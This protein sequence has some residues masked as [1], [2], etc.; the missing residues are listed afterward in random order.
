MASIAIIGAGLMGRLVALKLVQTQR[1]NTKHAKTVLKVCLFDKDAKTGCLSAA[2]AA[3]GLLTPLGESWCCENWIVEMGFDALALWPSILTQLELPVFFQRQG[4]V[5]VAHAED[6]GDMHRFKRHLKVNWPQYDGH[7]LDSAALQQLEPQLKR[8]NGGLY[9]PSEG[10]IDNRQLLVALRH[11]LTLAEAQG[12]FEWHCQQSVSAVKARSVEV[13]GE[14]RPFDLVIDC[15]G[16]GAA[17]QIAD[18]RGVRGELFRLYAPEVKLTRPV[19]LMHPRY[20][21]YIAP[22]PDH[23]YVIG[24]TEIESNDNGPMTVRSALEL[25][26]AAYSVH[27]GF[28]EASIVEHISQCRPAFDNNHPQIRVADGLIQVNGLYRHGFLL[29]PVVLEHLIKVIERLGEAFSLQADGNKDN[30]LAQLSEGL[31]YP[32]LIQRVI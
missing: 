14:L 13:N 9:L 22:K 17:T 24:A 1:Q 32:Q 7:N 27:S 21:L 2:S 23:H 26:S 18:L 6:S 4:T 10:Q 20:Q 5:A 3:A 31:D 25:L 11:Q 29:A 12:C 19:R 15:R 16:V 28:A 8:F 30:T